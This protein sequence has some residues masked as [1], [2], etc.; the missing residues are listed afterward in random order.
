[1]SLRAAH[2]AV[3]VSDGLAG[4]ALAAMLA[5]VAG[6]ILGRVAFDL[7]RGAVDLQIPGAIEIARYALLVTVMAALPG[8]LARGL[9]RV[10][11][12][13]DRLPRRVRALLA[14]AWAAL[15]LAWAGVL[16]WRLGAAALLEAG[17]GDATQDLGAPLWPLTAL[18]AA[19]AGLLALTAL[20]R[21]LGS[22]PESGRP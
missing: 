10:E 15:A 8:A 12:L 14:R 17:R 20:A 19:S 5:V 6:S 7:T 9:I 16:A 11:I 22:G 2:V 3:A 13:A 4:L 21:L 18:A 1:M